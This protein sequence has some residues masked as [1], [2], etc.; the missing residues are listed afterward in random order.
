MNYGQRLKKQQHSQLWQEYCGFLDLDMDEYMKIQNRLMQEQVRVWTSCG[1]GRKLLGGKQPETVEQF[2]K[3]MPLTTYDD[4]ADILLQKRGDQLPCEPVIWLQTTWEGGKHP[5]KTAP[6]TRGMLDVF[7]TNLMA[8]STLSASNGRGKISLRSGDKVLFGLAPLPYVTGLFPLLFEEEIDFKFL[9]PVKEAHKMSF[10]Q[11]SKKGFSMG[12]AQGIDVF[13]GLSSVISYIT[14]NFVSMFG[15]SGSKGIKKLL[16]CSPVMAFRFLRATY[17]CRRDERS[18]QPKDL[19]HLKSLVCA[20]TDTASYKPGLERAWGIKALEICA[21][22]EPTLIATETW[23][24]NGMVFFPDACFYEFIPEEEMN[25]NLEDPSYVPRTLLMNEVIPH[26]NY[27]LAITVL[28]GGAFARYRVGDVFRCIGIGDNG[29]ST[30]LPLFTFVDRTPDVIDIAGFTRITERS[31]AEV[32]EI[33]GLKIAY[34]LGKKE[35]D[36]KDRPYLHLYVELEEASLEKTAT[37][38]RVLKEHLE[39]Y[40]TYFDS[41]YE[42]LKKMLGIDPLK[43]TILKCGTVKGFKEMTGKSLRRINP[44]QLELLE[45]LKFDAQQP[46]GKWGDGQI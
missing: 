44:P 20:G 40:F 3:L 16:Q 11:R 43:I 8:V 22:T 13:F 4:Y 31:I 32:V 45:L 18:I 14:E 26:H 19:F 9:P 1:L 28:K 2:R 38:V 34:W 12:M 21:G 30:G 42:D 10:S 23:N 46:R 35:Y 33:S 37:S 25:R 29:K 41:D 7:K 27:E 36:E 17:E 24:H 5:I 6:Y 15:G 39:V